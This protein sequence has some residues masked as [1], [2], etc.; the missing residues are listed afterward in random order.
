LSP[1]EAF[2]NDA[3]MAEKM[4]SRQLDGQEMLGETSALI[5]PAGLVAQFRNHLLKIIWR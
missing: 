2:V 3:E 4:A 1:S 5:S